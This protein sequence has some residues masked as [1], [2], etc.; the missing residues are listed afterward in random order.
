MREP[1]AHAALDEARTVRRDG[2]AVHA[3]ERTRFLEHLQVAPH[4]L[5]RDVELRGELAHGDPPRIADGARDEIQPL[6]LI[7]NPD[8]TT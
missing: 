2:A 5:G 1:L 4:G 7:H 8:I 6:C 3:A